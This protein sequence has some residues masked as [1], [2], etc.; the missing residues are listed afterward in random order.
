VSSPL[1][2]DVFVAPYKLIGGLVAPMSEEAE[3]V[4]NWIR[5]TGKNL[6]AIYISHGHGDHFSGLNTI[7]AAFPDARAVTAPAVVAFAQG[8]V[9]PEGM[10]FWSALFPDQIPEH[11]LWTAAQGVFEQGQ[12]ASS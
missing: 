4:V 2:L 10:G 3:R 9:G 6:T 11:A 8:Q 5:A 7:L 1:S 12:G